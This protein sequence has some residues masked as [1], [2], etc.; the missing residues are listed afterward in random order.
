[1]VFVTG[2]THADFHRFNSIRF[3]MQK[4][5]TKEDVVIICGDFGGIW[6]TD[7]CDR[8]EKYWLDWLEKKSFTIC[9]CDGNHENFDRLNNFPIVNK[10]GAPMHQIRPSIFHMIRGNVYN[11]QD[12]TFFAFGGAHSHDITHGVLEKDDPRIKDWK[13]D[14][15]KLYRINHVSWWKE[16][17]PSLDEKEYAFQQMGKID[18]KVDFII[19]HTPPTEVLFQM[20][21]R[22]DD[23]SNFLQTFVNNTKYKKW[24]CGHMHDDRYFP[25]CN[26]YLLY[27]DIIRI[28]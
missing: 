17:A 2:D 3:P 6:S 11:I 25:I 15:Y 13:H 5:L 22:S 21:Y 10:F 27:E 8:S 14:R 19:T 26:T 18:H 1:M 16:E 9:F 12:H 20:G 23:I 24:F 4:E 28:I 7:E